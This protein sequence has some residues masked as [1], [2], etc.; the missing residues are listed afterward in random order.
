MNRLNRNDRRE[1]ERELR[2]MPAP[3][4]PADLLDKIR[5][6]IPADLRAANEAGRA[7]PLHR[8]TA[9]K[10]AAS[11]A[12]AAVGI[13]LAWRTMERG[14]ASPVESTFS[15]PAPATVLRSDV[16]AGDSAE[17][18]LPYGG[19]AGDRLAEEVGIDAA[20][21]AAPE[22]ERQKAAAAD[23]DGTVELDR[24][25][26]AQLESLGYL[27][28]GGEMG[29]VRAQA[30]APAPPAP[31]E[32]QSARRIAEAGPAP[33]SPESSARGRR[34]EPAG[35]AGGVEGRLEG[36]V[37]GGVVGGVPSPR[38][39]TSERE[40]RASSALDKSRKD[41]EVGSAATSSADE[42]ARTVEMPARPPRDDAFEEKAA[43][44]DAM[45][46]RPV[47]TN[48]FVETARDKLSTFALDV[49][50][51]S[52]ALARRYLHDGN[53]PPAEAIRVEEFV[54]AQTY[55]DPAPRRGDFTLTA[56]G[57]ASPFAGGRGHRLLRFGVKARE[58]DAADRKSAVLTFV[59]DV[60]GSMDREN[61]LGL[62]KRALGLLL[63]EL[64]ADD[65]VGLVVYGS[66]GRVLLHHTRD[67]EA[68]RRAISRLVP[69]GST[70]A[71]EGLRLGYD[72]ADEG[73]R[74]GWI[75]RIV[76]CS[77]GVA[78]VG[79]TGPE[80]ILERIGKEARRGIELTTVG[81]GMGNYNDELM[82]QLADQGDGSYHYVDTLDAARQ[83]FVENLTGTLQTVAKDAK[84]QVEFDAR[85]VER[86]RL[87]GYENRDVAD[88]DFRN[89]RVDAGEVGVGQTATA[90]YE[91]RLREGARAGDPVA[92]LRLR[93]KSREAGRVI[94]GAQTLHVR[95]LGEGFDDASRD[96]R[97]AALAAEL[98]ERLKGS[99]HARGG[100]WDALRGEAD[101]LRREHSRDRDVI[102]LADLVTRAARL[103]GGSD[104]DPDSG[105]RGRRDDERDD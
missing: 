47:G 76:L 8:T 68:I 99:R 46:F 87:V 37:P 19:K 52:Y 61:R 22:P 3:P 89:D 28:A 55:G 16:A 49:D 58:I 56:E 86:W 48:P 18:K 94:E 34:N 53:L 57:A 7:K 73:W 43:E 51:G 44:P 81:F 1:L 90:L 11:I 20:P 79:A 9:F 83:V 65:R 26:I 33:P 17:Q 6:D 74:E 85:S 27:G 10:L 13:G 40:R 92:T 15:R 41:E 84:V 32:P 98:A 24:E 100:S 105:R 21:F 23:A 63:D 45:Y 80:S 39:A 103:D 95:D 101:Y 5:A 70:N 88:R 64:A 36:G 59:V 69:E 75:N 82:E 102:E 4:P 2:E 93:W 29:D 91:V 66:N 78:N 42:F 31:A 30:P 35:V 12:V 14:S 67:H 62:V 25:T 38:V 104:E 77:D 54:N 96:L 97:V 60:S 50:T 72:L 71:E